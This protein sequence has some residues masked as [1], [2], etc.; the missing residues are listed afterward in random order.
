MMGNG[1]PPPG[2]YIP[3]APLFLHKGTDCHLGAGSSLPH[4]WIP[5]GPVLTEPQATD[6]PGQG[7]PCCQRPGHPHPDSLLHMQCLVWDPVYRYPAELS[8]FL[9]IARGR[10]CPCSPILLLARLLVPLCSV[11]NPVLSSFMFYFFKGKL[12]QK[13]TFIIVSIG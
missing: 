10:G 9:V 4:L 5:K 12:F 13:A 6:R 7:R 3:Q 2:P 1:A 11:T 8:P